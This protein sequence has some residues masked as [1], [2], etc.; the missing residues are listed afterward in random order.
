MFFLFLGFGASGDLPRGDE[1]TS[2]GGPGDRGAGAGHQLPQPGAHLAGLLQ[3][4]AWDLKS[5]QNRLG[6]LARLGAFAGRLGVVFDLG[7][8]SLAMVNSCWSH[9]LR[10]GA[11]GGCFIYFLRDT[12]GNLGVRSHPNP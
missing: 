3:C 9:F 1:A 6:G 5:K 8:N 7:L 4:G 12:G 11:E 2:H 10:F